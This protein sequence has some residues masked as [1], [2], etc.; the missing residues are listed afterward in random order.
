MILVCNVMWILSY[1]QSGQTALMKA[2]D[3]GHVACV[4]LLLENGADVDHQDGV[5]ALSLSVWHVL[6]YNTCRGTVKVTYILSGN[7]CTQSL[8]RSY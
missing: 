3:G 1:L 2:S 5:S 6:L 7:N 4:M 8:Y